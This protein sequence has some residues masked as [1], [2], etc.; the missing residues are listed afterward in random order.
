MPGD[1]AVA[2]ANG[3][4]AKRARRERIA[5]E[6][7]ETQIVELRVT[8]TVEDSF[9]V[10]QTAGMFDVPLAARAEERIVFERPDLEGEWSIGLIVGPSGSGKSTAAQR[11]FGEAVWRG[12]R[13]ER[14]R[15]VIDAF[16]PLGIRETAGL[17]TAVGFGSPPSWIKPY[18]VLSNG[19]RFRCELAAALAAGGREGT[20]A[21]DEFTSVV[22]RDVAKAC[23]T[24]V[25]RAVRRERIARRFV[26]VT[27]HYDVAEWLE[28]D[29][30]LDLASGQ[31]SRRRL[32]RPRMR[33]EMH[34]CS[35]AAWR[36]FARHH[37]LNGSL[38][39]TARCYL[40]SWDGRATAFCA[41]MPCIGSRGR[42]RITR[43]V[44]LP[45]Y[46]G[47]GI[48]GRLLDATAELLER[49]GRSVS[50]TASHPGLIGHCRSSSRWRAV[51]LMKT[52]SRRRG[53]IAG[54]RGSAGRCVATFAFCGGGAAVKAVEDGEE[55]D[56]LAAGKRGV[57]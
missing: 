34:R 25:A 35:V 41:A 14:N 23:A 44:T 51:R 4:S 32:R 6:T 57:A 7:P 17:L 9:R 12:R 47:M 13:W 15:A 39:P 45:D 55:D 33:I 5:R 54:Y 36:L 38:S 24:A 53:T 16:E 19:E 28:P 29:W 18:R 50:V 31:C 40:A 3:A 43:L 26:A 37:Y 10:Q 46:Q 11:L 22:D 8:C 30:V 20:T 56:R 2:V 27:C 48:G 1:G 49:E 52:G 21:F 42:W